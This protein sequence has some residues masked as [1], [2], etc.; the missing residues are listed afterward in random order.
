MNRF[1]SFWEKF[2]ARIDEKSIVSVR[3]AKKELEDRFDRESIERLTYHNAEFFEM[4]SVAE[5]EFIRTIYSVQHF[6]QNLEK[7]KL[8]K[9]GYLADPFLIAKASIQKGIVV[10]EEGLKP[11]A[12]KVPNICEHFGVECVTLETFLTRENWSF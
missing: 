4:P 1:P 12:A 5:L 9:G 3:E 11:H 2:L 10:C 8:L 6:Q 7:K